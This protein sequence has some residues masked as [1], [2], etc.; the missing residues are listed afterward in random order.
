MYRFLF[1]HILWFLLNKCL[2]VKWLDNTVSVC[3]TSS[4]RSL[5]KIGIY[6]LHV[7]LSNFIYSDMKKGKVVQSCPTLCD[8]VDCRVHGILQARILEQVAFPFSRGL[9]NPGIEPRSSALQVDSLPAEPQ[10]KPKYTGVG[11]LSLLQRIFLTQELNWGLLHCRWML[12]QLSYQGSPHMVIQI[13]IIMK[14]IEFTC[15]R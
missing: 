6:F 12:Y 1:G 13:Y 15:A 4:L 5:C 9:P 3:L 14:Y 11:S 10:G 2:G 7:F 8:P